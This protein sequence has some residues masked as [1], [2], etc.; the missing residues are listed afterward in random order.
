MTPAEIKLALERIEPIL[1][2]A[3]VAAGWER[4]DIIFWDFDETCIGLVGWASTD[5]E[6]ALVSFEDIADKLT[7]P[8]IYHNIISV[9]AE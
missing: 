7:K 8:S 1:T 5:K 6:E 3:G 4:D 2:A 9:I